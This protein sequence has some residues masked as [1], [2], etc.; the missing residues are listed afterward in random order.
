V[1]GSLRRAIHEAAG[2]I[3]V[4]LLCL[5]SCLSNALKSMCHFAALAPALRLYTACGFVAPIDL[6]RLPV[7]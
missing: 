2:I 4:V 5:V 6:L 1:Y 7:K 3:F